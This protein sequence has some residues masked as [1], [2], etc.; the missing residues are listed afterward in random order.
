M[1]SI[2]ARNSLLLTIWGARRLAPAP[3]S[4][5]DTA[6]KVSTIRYY[7]N[8]PLMVKMIGIKSS[9]K[10]A[11]LYYRESRDGETSSMG[12]IWGAQYESDIHFGVSRWSTVAYDRCHDP[13][14][15][16]HSWFAVNGRNFKN[17]REIRDKRPK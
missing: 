6:L 8:A 17:G 11:L 7:Y 2:G 13:N 1:T 5:S 9:V 10:Q 12:I 14:S 3:C 16:S 4:I 15:V